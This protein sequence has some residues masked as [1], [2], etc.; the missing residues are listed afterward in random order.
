VVFF[1]GVFFKRLNARG[2]LAA[3]GVG[4]LLGPFRLAVDT[5]LKL[6]PTGF[7][8]GYAEGSFLWIVNNTFFE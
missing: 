5:P 8:G 3:L 1:L 2:S 6:G 7:E 4:F